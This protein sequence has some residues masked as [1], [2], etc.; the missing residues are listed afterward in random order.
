[1]DHE[2]Q[3]GDADRLTENSTYPIKSTVTLAAP[4]RRR[5]LGDRRDPASIPVAG[6]HE[7]LVICAGGEYMVETGRHYTGRESFI[8]HASSVSLVDITQ[9]H[10]VTVHLEIPSRLESENFILTVGFACSV[11]SAA[12]VVRSGVRDL[13][14]R[15]QNYLESHHLIYT[16][17]TEFDPDEVHDLRRDMGAG[18]RSLQD[19]DPI[20]IPGIRAELASWHVKTS[21][22]Y[23]EVNRREAEERRRARLQRVSAE[24][25]HWTSTR[26]IE[27]NRTIREMGAD[28]I[29]D[30]YE[31]TLAEEV[32]A[33][34]ARRERHEQER[35]RERDR[36]IDR[37]IRADRDYQDR[38]DDLAYE[39]A[40]EAEE[41]HWFRERA[42]EQEEWKVEQKFRYLDA[43]REAGAFKLVDPDR[44]LSFL[45]Q[46]MGVLPEGQ[47]ARGLD[48]SARAS[49]A[50][51]ASTETSEAERTGLNNPGKSRSEGWG[52]DYIDLIDDADLACGEDPPR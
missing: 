40:R 31:S 30:A 25:R 37:R 51:V 18:L 12:E 9:R 14:T 48:S 27:F 21:S 52:E 32:G 3:R 5:L 8:A 39:R 46:E 26:Q 33:V 42:K 15:L 16:M 44:V 4:E 7:A 23:L 45:E 36:D 41:R 28:A 19:L 49:S 34:A 29:E 35:A 20:T 13:G 43:L 1:M 2:V 38:R 50:P 24:E 22:E 11:T 47:P 10:V 17:G 6:P